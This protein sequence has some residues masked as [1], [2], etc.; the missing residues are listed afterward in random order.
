MGLSARA[1]CCPSEGGVVRGAGFRRRTAAKPLPASLSSKGVWRGG[2]AVWRRRR[3]TAVTSPSRPSNSRA[4]RSSRSRRL[5]CDP[6]PPSP[7][8][9]DAL[10]F[11]VQRASAADGEGGFRGRGVRVVGERGGGG[12]GDLFYDGVG[13]VKVVDGRL[14]VSDV[15]I[16]KG[17]KGEENGWEG[18]MGGGREGERK[19]TRE[20]QWIWLSSLRHDAYPPPHK[21][22][23]KQKL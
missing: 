12:E 16:R 2:R 20:I 22:H 6:R 21:L 7:G 5:P 23:N 11:G 13:R 14:C 15:S 17:R 19:G 8:Q 1:A 9:A 3:S 18:G 4:S 10:T